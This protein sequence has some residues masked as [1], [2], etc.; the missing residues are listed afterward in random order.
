MSKHSKQSYFMLVKIQ[1]NKSLK[2]K[3][4]AIWDKGLMVTMG[5]GHVECVLGW[6]EGCHF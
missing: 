3:M 6:L 5:M 2:L 1:K 4:P